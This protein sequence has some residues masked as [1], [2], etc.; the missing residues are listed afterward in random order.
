MLIAAIATTKRRI[1]RRAAMSPDLC[2]LLLK[3]AL[4]DPGR[5]GQ[6]A[7]REGVTTVSEEGYNA[8]ML[9]RRRVEPFTRPFV[10]A[11][12]RMSRGLTLGVRGIV[13]DADGRVL[14]VEHTYVRGWYLPGGGVERGESA[15]R[16]LERE[17][18][19]EAGVSL[20]DRPR[21]V[22]VHDNGDRHPRD[23]VLLYH[24]AAW[25][26]C[27]ARPGAEIHAVAWFHPDALPEGATPA[28]RARIREV[29]GGEDGDLKW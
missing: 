14:L 8:V 27:A 13:T 19:E 16:A 21:L 15:E 1:G 10:Y 12:F 26:P 3:P 7:V 2:V 22:S 5:R 4:A 25:T 6:A 9:W 11:W 18:Q 17:L 29:L 28:T 23:H 20:T 24:C